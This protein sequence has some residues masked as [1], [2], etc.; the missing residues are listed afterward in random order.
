MLI[1]FGIS[2]ALA[3]YHYMFVVDL[4]C[5]WAFSQLVYIPNTWQH[6]SL[7]VESIEALVYV[8]GQEVIKHDVVLASIDLFQLTLAQHNLNYGDTQ[9][10][11]V[12]LLMLSKQT[13]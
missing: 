11:W 5:R 7:E 1:P 2:H 13:C 3:I 9:H 6:V 10:T 12:K 8:T 4:R